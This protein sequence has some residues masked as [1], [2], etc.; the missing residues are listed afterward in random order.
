MTKGPS[1]CAD[2]KHFRNEA[3]VSI[4]HHQFCIAPPQN[5]PKMNFTTG[6]LDEPQPIFCRDRNPDGEC[7]LFEKETRKRWWSL[8]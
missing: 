1:I 3:N 2:C 7:Q 4:W 5:E 8:I 6:R